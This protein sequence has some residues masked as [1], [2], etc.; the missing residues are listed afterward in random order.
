M[1][2]KV[3]P[4]VFISYSWDSPSHKK[5]VEELAKELVNY[6]AKVIFDRWDMKPGESLTQFM[7]LGIERA[8]FVLVIC[9]PNYAQKSNARRG[10]VGYEQQIISGRMAL[11]L[12]DKSFIP[13]VRKGNLLPGKDCA[14]PTHLTGLFTLTMKSRGFD[15]D[16]FNDLIQAIFALP[17]HK[18]PP[19]RQSPLFKP[20]IRK[21]KKTKTSLRLPNVELDG[22]EIRSGKVANELY[23]KTFYIPSERARKTVQKGDLVKLIF[24]IWDK[25]DKDLF[26]ERMWV[27]ITNLRSVYYVGKLSN[28]P[29]TSDKKGGPLKWGDTVFFLPEH[30]IEIEK[31]S[32]K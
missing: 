2:K 13:I 22:Y 7:E 25:E 3:S 14:V 1:S 26:G 27:K 10:G 18:P 29:L 24:G 23:P 4:T 32:Q 20:K 6:S 28:Q 5:W 12:K 15:N 8:D 19:L 16:E 11:G 21:N 30:V 9:T 17:G 31:K